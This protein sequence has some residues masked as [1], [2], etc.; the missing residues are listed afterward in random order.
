MGAA[1]YLVEAGKNGFLLEND[2]DQYAQVLTGLLKDP[3]KCKS[4]GE[5][6]YSVARTNYTWDNVGKLMYSYIGAR[7]D[8]GPVKKS[9][10]N[11]DYSDAN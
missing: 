7:I 6:S 9:E 1:P 3:Q 10:V 4:F 8:G 2:V 11:V 5:H